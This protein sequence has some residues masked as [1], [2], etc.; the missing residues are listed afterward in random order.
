M[1]VEPTAVDLTETEKLRRL[2]WAFAH[3][4]TNA[5]FCQLT[6]FGPVFILFLTELG[7]DKAQIGLLLAFFPLA[8]VIAPLVAP[9]V[10]RLGY[11]RVFVALWGTRKAVVAGLLLTPFIAARW[12]PAGTLRFVAAD[13]AAFA[14]CRAIA[15]T[16]MYPWMR[17]FVPDRVRGRFAAM[18]NILA[19]FFGFL[20]ISFAGSVIGQRPGLDGYMMLIGIG[21]V[22]GVLAVIAIAF[23]PGGAP[24]HAV[25]SVRP[26]LRVTWATLHDRRFLRF[27]IG[28]GLM[29]LAVVPLNSFLALFARE[30][31]GLSQANVIFLQAGV[32]TG[33]LLLSYAWGWAADRFGSR[34]IMLT[35]ALAAVLLPFLW[36]VA[37]AHNPW[38]FGAAVGIA[39]VTGAVQ[40]AWSIGS[41]RFLFMDV[42][43]PTQTPQYMA[44]FY[45]SAGITGALSA[46]L[47]GRILQSLQ[48]L[49]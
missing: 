32:L 39:F 43:P 30:H 29:T 49:P 40:P 34:P 25:G 44:A 13:I 20:A 35:G 47:S 11:K 1:N 37:P 31:L 42:V 6:V 4:A 48:T 3:I 17:E 27:L 33:G 36:L 14:L 28:T 45:A 23:V 12:G 10:A 46:T 9:L 8:G 5:V 21:V 16:G 15:E 22:F 18:D 38:T 41:S 26:N 24:Q 2:P 19:T 7:L